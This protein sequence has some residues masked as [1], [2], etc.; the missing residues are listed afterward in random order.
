MKPHYLYT[1]KGYLRIDISSIGQGL[2]CGGDQ[3][4]VSGTEVNPRTAAGVQK[5]HPPFFLN[6]SVASRNFPLRFGVFQEPSKRDGMTLRLL[7]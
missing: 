7:K 5:L 2:A 4:W 3:G 6:I 1:S